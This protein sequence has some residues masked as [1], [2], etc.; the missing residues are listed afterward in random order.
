[1]DEK[2]Y[3]SLDALVPICPFNQM[4]SHDELGNIETAF[5]A[6]IET[7]LEKALYLINHETL[8][9]TSLFLLRHDI[10][11]HGVFDQL[12]LRN[13]TA[14]S[15]VNEILLGKRD[16]LSIPCSYCDYIQTVHSVLKWILETGSIDDGLNNEYD[17][18]L[19]IT[20]ILLIKTYGD[21][22]ILPTIVDIIFKRYAE[23]LFIND[24]AWAFFQSHDPNS[25]IFI[26][27]RLK[28]T[29]PK[30]VEL[31]RKLLMFCPSIND[32]SKTPEEYTA[33]T[34][35]L[36]ENSLF[37]YFTGESF[38]QSTKPMPYVV[39]LEAKYL[40]KTVDL[41]TGRIFE[42]FTE[43]E[44]RLLGAYKKLDIDTKILLAN[45]SYKLHQRDL[46]TWRTWIGR[47]IENQ[48]VIARSIMG[49][50]Q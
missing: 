10:E 4:R 41:L 2:Y 39:I 20:A 14:L 31:A 3:L 17:Q 49:V 35:W 7:D 36:K 34:D 50:R 26:A 38:Q 28:S 8:P 22:T 19:D 42:T 23:G 11:K 21:K 30:E 25:L 12:S 6:L 46:S 43:N 45:C 29:N 27:D 9:F 13:R 32:N 18:V 5:R 37:L 40:Y 44:S 47:P 1:M 33:F 16:T 15:I 48:I 24:L